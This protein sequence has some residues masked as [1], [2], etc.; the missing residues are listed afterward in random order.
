MKLTKKNLGFFLTLLGLGLVVG[1][2]SWEI[3]ERIFAAAGLAFDI[4]AGPIGFDLDVIS[5]YI[6]VNPGSLVG[7][8]GG[9]FLFSRL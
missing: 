2:L 7:T 3:V 4:S 6:R 1:T 8:A 5:F 9:G